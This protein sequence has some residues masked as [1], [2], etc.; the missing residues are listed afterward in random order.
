M[1]L[2]QKKINDQ[3]QIKQLL[4]CKARIWTQAVWPPASRASPSRRSA[5]RSLCPASRLPFSL[6]VGSDPLLPEKGIQRQC[7]LS[8]KTLLDQKKTKMKRQSKAFVS[9]FSSGKENGRYNK[10][11]LWV[12]GMAQQLNTAQLQTYLGK[13]TWTINSFYFH[14]YP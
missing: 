1:K 6:H 14:H 8:R 11:Y 7:S 10:I 13:D 3:P 2:K 4:G 12:L 9:I 5:A